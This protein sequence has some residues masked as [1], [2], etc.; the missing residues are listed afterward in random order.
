MLRE[1]LSSDLHRQ[2]CYEGPA[3]IR[4]RQGHLD[5]VKAGRRCTSHSSRRWTELLI[6]GTRLASVNHEIMIVRDRHGV[7][8]RFA[9]FLP[10]RERKRLVVR[11]HSTDEETKQPSQ[12]RQS[13]KLLVPPVHEQV[14]VTKKKVR[15]R[16][17]SNF[18]DAPVAE[19]ASA[20]E[21]DFFWR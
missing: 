17:L 1:E 14:R 10:D 4:A 3:F 18:G 13:P 16:Q 20:S 12:R 11:H 8:H 2:R 19:A 6:R 5:T 9:R 7:C 15:K 21:D